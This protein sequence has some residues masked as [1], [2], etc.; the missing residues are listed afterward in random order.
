[1]P[2]EATHWIAAHR[3]AACL[4]GTEWG[5]AAQRCPG[6]LQLGAVFPD[7]P[8][9][10][11]G[12][13]SL[14]RNAAELGNRYHGAHGEDSYDLLRALLASLRE[15]GAEPHQAMLVGVAS[16]LC[17]D[18]SFH[19]WVYYETGNYYD[20]DPARR[21]MAVRDHRR[22]EGWLDI[23]VCGGID[24][25]RSYRATTIWQRMEQSP[26]LLLQWAAR[27]QKHFNVERILEAANARFLEAQSWFGNP[28]AAR[29]AGWIEP[30]LPPSARELT[31]LFYQCPHSEDWN[32]LQGVQTFRN[33]VTGE[34]ASASIE[35]LLERGVEA[36]VALCRAMETVFRRGG[37]EEFTGCGLSLNFGVAGAGV[38]QARYFAS[39]AR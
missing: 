12:T 15:D 29:V 21:T 32:R 4:A 30:L 7:L 39:P 38:E 5:A 14:A 20:P 2:K 8:Y 17:V 16:H 33:P 6:A 31:A 22:L 23:V 11:T 35:E 37:G 3:T 18:A 34:T 19:P 26:E 36:G 10:L 28:V 9:Y 25:V 13:S 27:H 1:M 24:Q